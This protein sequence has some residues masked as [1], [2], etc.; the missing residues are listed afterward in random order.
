[1]VLSPAP[2]SLL[3]LILLLLAIFFWFLVAIRRR[4]IWLP[5]LSVL[6]VP[7]DRFKK[8]EMKAPPWLSFW[9]FVL[10]G[11]T[12]CF[13][14]LEPVQSDNEGDVKREKVHIFL[15]LSPSLSAYAT[16]SEYHQEV[17]KV[18]TELLKKHSLTL[19]TS[20]SSEIESFDSLEQAQAVLERQFKKGYHRAGIELGSVFKSRLAQLSDVKSVIVIS[21]QNFHSWNQ[22]NWQA[23]AGQKT[24]RF[25]NLKREIPELINTY[26]KSVRQITGED[27][28]R[29]LWDITIAKVGAGKAVQG[30]L[31]LILQGKIIASENWQILAQGAVTS[32]RVSLSRQ[33]LG[34]RSTDSREMLLW[35]L[36]ITGPDAISA[37]NEFRSYISAKSKQVMLVADP[38]G[39]SAL[40]DPVAPLKTALEVLNFHYQRLDNLPKHFDA[41]SYALAIYAVGSLNDGDL[42]A[43]PDVQMKSKAKIW[44]MPATFDKSFPAL[45]SCI[46]SLSSNTSFDR[47]RC[48]DQGDLKSFQTFMRSFGAKQKLGEIADAESTLVWAMPTEDVDISVYVFPL[49]PQRLRRFTH[50]DFLIFVKNQLKMNKLWYENSSSLE[51]WP[52]ILHLDLAEVGAEQAMLSNVPEGESNFRDIE[53]ASLPP[54]FDARV[55]KLAELGSLQAEYSPKKILSVLYSLVFAVLL[56]EVLVVFYRRRQGQIIILFFCL[57][58]G[59][60]SQALELDLLGP[61][62]KVL[63]DKTNEEVSSRTSLTLLNKPNLYLSLASFNY[64]HPWLWAYELKWLVEPKGHLPRELIEWLKRGGFL[65]IENAHGLQELEKATALAFGENLRPGKWSVVPHDHELMRSFYLLD[66]LV[67]CGI[68]QPWHVYTYDHRSIIF[69]LPISLIELVYAGKASSCAKIP[70]REDL[71]RL[72]I[73]TLMIALTI[74]YKKDQAQIQETIDRLRQRR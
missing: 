65:I 4:R 56:L 44:L 66:G 13:L 1:M 36:N 73:N 67:S 25:V 34:L 38:Q 74:D 35:Q 53:M 9:L 31:S 43:C 20:H 14:F 48:Q 11:L 59:N 17:L 57:V 54:L 8:M 37:D 10:L 58:S 29:F 5:I 50:T 12:V 40:E 33:S 68:D 24:V 39:E 72:Y 60:E 18:V 45:C 15:D 70:I 61:Y 62:P 6:K 42:T 69:A 27:L 49:A 7:V 19:S 32:V 51:N 41:S 21:D 16:L 23:L 2:L 46:V 28:E 64:D 55:K 52:R 26:I 71:L 63:F 22:F 3:A 47:G 30:T